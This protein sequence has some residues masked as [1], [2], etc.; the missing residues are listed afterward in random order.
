MVQ[1][2]KMSVTAS[3]DTNILIEDT[4][5]FY[6]LLYIEKKC[7]E[8]EDKMNVYFSSYVSK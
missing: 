4:T 2:K 5:L 7:Y 3:T 1:H 6:A 8:V